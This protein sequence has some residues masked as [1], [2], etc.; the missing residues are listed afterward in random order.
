[1]DSRMNDAGKEI[2][3]HDFTSAVDSILR[4]SALQPQP[5]LG[6]HGRV[7]GRGHM[8]DAIRPWH[9][10]SNVCHLHKEI[11]QIPWMFVHSPGG[12]DLLSHSENPDFKLSS[13]TNLL[14]IALDNLLS[15]CRSQFSHC[16]R[17]FH[18][19]FLILLS[20]LT[21]DGLMIYSL[22]ISLKE[23]ARQWQ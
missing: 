23:V 18:R 3:S 14:S 16:T 5:Q 21:F 11:P 7:T 10:N 17:G 6:C 9:N 20:A 1:M 4:L 13:V 8:D 19:Q 15:Y 22:F 12:A 2:E